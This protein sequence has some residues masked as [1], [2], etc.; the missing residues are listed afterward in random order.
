MTGVKVDKQAGVARIQPGNIFQDLIPKLAKEDVCVPHGTC[1]TVGIAG[2]TMGGGWGPWTRMHGMCCESRVGAPIVLGNGEAIELTPECE[3]KE[4]LW[5]LRGGGGFSYGI[6]TELVI[7]TFDLPKTT[8]KFNAVW[9]YTPA[10][11]VLKHWEDWIAADKNKQL[12]GTNL[13]IMAIPTPKESIP[14]RETVHSCTF[15][16]YFA[17][18]KEELREHMKVW[19]ADLVP[20]TVT[21]IPPGIVDG[22]N[23][24]HNFDLW[25][26]LTSASP[27]LGRNRPLLGAKNLFK[28]TDLDNDAL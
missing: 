9:Q 18:S 12:I 2:F 8:I 1:G 15:Y 27:L 5:A 28:L 14:I 16:G 7:K 26:R 25:D 4:L 21:I 17:G 6:V 13:M 3:Q 24:P 20:T 22:K 10:F 23:Q 11:T 19:F